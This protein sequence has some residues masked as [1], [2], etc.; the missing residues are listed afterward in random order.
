MDATK[1]TAGPPRRTE[2]PTPAADLPTRGPPQAEIPKGGADQP[3]NQRASPPDMAASGS[4]E[5]ANA[6]QP[7]TGPDKAVPDAEHA[8][9]LPPPTAHRAQP[10]GLAD[11]ALF[12]APAHHSETGAPGNA[13]SG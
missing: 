7:G 6:G 9:G 3:E 8:A 2:A 13:A 4:E 12:A 10:V 5:A 11:A 1:K